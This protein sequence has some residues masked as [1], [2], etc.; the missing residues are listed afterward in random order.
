[1]IWKNFYE[2]KAMLTLRKQKQSNCYISVKR[3]GKLTLLLDP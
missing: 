3:P 2:I 1:M